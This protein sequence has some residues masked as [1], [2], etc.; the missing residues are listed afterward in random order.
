[1]AQPT[2]TSTTPPPVL[3]HPAA[4]L[5]LPSTS[6]ASSKDSSIAH[7]WIDMS[8]EHSGTIVKIAAVA[9]KP[10]DVKIFPTTLSSITDFH[11][12][13]NVLFEIT[14]SKCRSLWREGRYYLLKLWE[15]EELLQRFKVNIEGMGIQNVI[16]D[17]MSVNVENLFQD[18]QEWENRVK[19][20]RNTIRNQ[21]RSIYFSIIQKWNV[22]VINK[23]KKTC[24]TSLTMEGYVYFVNREKNVYINLWNSIH[25]FIKMIDD[26]QGEIKKVEPLFDELLS[27]PKADFKHSEDNRH[28]N[29]PIAKAWIKEL[30]NK[31]KDLI[32]WCEGAEYLTK[33]AQCTH[34]DS[35]DK[36]NLM[37]TTLSTLQNGLLDLNIV[38]L[39]KSP[40]VL[41]EDKM[42]LSE[43]KKS[44]ELAINMAEDKM[45]PSENTPEAHQAKIVAGTITKEMLELELRMASQLH[46]KAQ[47]HK[48]Q[49]SQCL[50][51]LEK[52]RTK[53]SK[54]VE[55]LRQ[56][57]VDP[58]PLEWPSVSSTASDKGDQPG[59]WAY[60]PAAGWIVYFF[61][62]TPKVERKKIEEP[63]PNVIKVKPQFTDVPSL[64]PTILGHLS[65]NLRQTEPTLV[66]RRDS[67]YFPEVRW[68]TEI[69]PPEVIMSNSDHWK[70]HLSGDTPQGCWLKFDTNQKQRLIDSI[71][72]MIS[73]HDECLKLNSHYQCLVS[74]L[75]LPNLSTNAQDYVH[76]KLFLLSELK[77][78]LKDRYLPLKVVIEGIMRELNV[79]AQR[80]EAQAIKITT[81][82]DEHT[83]SRLTE[84]RS[85]GKSLKEV[86]AFVMGV[87]EQDEKIIQD[88]EDWLDDQPGISKPKAE[89]IA[90]LDSNVE[91]RKQTLP[92]PRDSEGHETAK[93]VS[94]LSQKYIPLLDVLLKLQI[95]TVPEDDFHA[96]FSLSLSR[97]TPEA[98][99]QF[100]RAMIEREI[101]N[102]EVLHKCF[103]A[104]VT[105]FEKYVHVLNILMEDIRVLQWDIETLTK[106]TSDKNQIGV[107][108]GTLRARFAIITRHHQ[109]WR[110][111]VEQVIE[112][113]TQNIALYEKK[114]K[115]NEIYQSHLQMKLRTSEK[116]KEMMVAFEQRKAI[117]EMIKDSI[118]IRFNDQI[119]TGVD[120]VVDGLNKLRAKQEGKQDISPNHPDCLVN[121]F[122][123][124]AKTPTAVSLQSLTP[125]PPT[126]TPPP[127]RAKNSP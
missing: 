99:Q 38:K 32:M 111:N 35:V 103:V 27:R 25:N 40:E 51:R 14:E 115:Q 6:S 55:S 23:R 39:P 92:N 97:M 109:D 119:V 82:T 47:D 68:G 91:A 37:S 7:D 50:L 76:G 52:S 96:Q 71:R 20:N 15:Y 65:P 1:M 116:I 9:L 88:V 87:I 33:K 106:I 49:L 81:S 63:V 26:V 3:T 16:T 19:S 125:P 44:L 95:I 60:F 24:T 48:L 22:P 62:G 100:E 110:S 77:T 70:T 112:F 118:K 12:Q 113:L 78:L 80:L 5:L 85:G 54:L 46:A 107:V 74:M 127:A 122:K 94:E 102:W 86:K 58:Q 117:L 10:E 56:V 29:F 98:L 53:M 57:K 8:R 41:P 73:L 2:P 28:T 108:Y 93:K 123:N 75:K 21:L 61:S 83:K 43:V 84:L 126:L 42:T 69:T 45:E 124:P 90:T 4:P 31:L 79:V 72:S 120:S 66:G 114:L 121:P 105:D 67:D 34:L 11:S 18:I 30:E 101:T 59:W 89:W 64:S 36:Q 17:T 104:Q 13:H